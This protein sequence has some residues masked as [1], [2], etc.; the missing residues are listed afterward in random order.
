MLEMR[1]L[2]MLH[3]LRE[4]GSLA[5]AADVLCVTASAVSHQLRELEQHFGVALV[6]RRTR[7]LSFTGAGEHLLR[8]GDEVLP[9]I[10]RAESI[11]SRLS[12]GQAGRLRLASECHSCFDWLMPVLAEYRRTW[13]DV[14]IDF[15][16]AFDPD[17]HRSLVLGEI[18][19]LITSSRL[20]T[21]HLE[22]LPL[23]SYESRLVMAPNHPL[24]TKD[25]IHPQD[26]TDQTLIVY[27]VDINRLD[28][29]AHFLLP[30]GVLPKTRQIELVQMLI[31]LAASSKGVA[32]L[33]DWVVADYEQKGYVTSRALGS[34]VFCWLYAATARTHAPA[35]FVQGFL[36]R[37]KAIQKP[38]LC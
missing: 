24:A 22:Y 36:A 16:P 35:P 21:E 13:V 6:N 34:G 23:F 11:L 3:A 30:A 27:P 29:M 31:Q 4:C 14:E 10:A 33:P 7:P 20:D 18:D 2:Q 25:S 17:L 37:L 28:I 5:A 26:L 12:S 1:H 32:S 15:A 9:K 19:V 8:L 38:N